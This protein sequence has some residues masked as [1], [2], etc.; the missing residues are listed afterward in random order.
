MTKR[1]PEGGEEALTPREIG[2]LGE[3]LAAR[4]LYLR[5]GFRILRR[6][7]KAPR[8]GEVDLV[9]RDGETLAFVEVKA[10]RGR[11]LGRPADAVDAKKQS[12]ITRGAM[13]WL[14]LLD[15]PEVC[16]RFD[17]VE[18]MLEEGEVP[19]V[20]LIREAFHLPEPMRY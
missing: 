2:E 12:L 7:F 18:V 15:H 5:E 6:N 19:E 13:R 17:V 16:F 4:H 1:T 10:R 3:R 20:T 9:C 8:G 14:R 11:A